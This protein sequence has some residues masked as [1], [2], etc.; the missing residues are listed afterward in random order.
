ML[1]H[2][3][4]VF[5]IAI[6]LGVLFHRYLVVLK[7]LTPCFIFCIL[8]LSFSAFQIKNLKFKGLNMW[9][10]IFQIV[11]SISAYYLFRRRSELLAQGFLIGIICPVAAS[12]SVVACILGAN[13][14]TITSYTLIGNLAVA[15]V[16]PLYFT[17]IGVHPEY[18]FWYS[19]LMILAKLAPIL[20]LPLIVALLLQRFAPKVTNVLVRY[21]WI[22]FYIWAVTL[23]IV[24]GQTIDYIFNSSR[25]Q[26]VTILVLAAASMITCFI[27]F[28]VGRWIGKK[29]GDTVSGG[30]GLAQKNAAM[31]VWMATIYLN[32]LASVF[33]ACYSVWQN[34][35]NSW[36]IYRHDKKE[37][38]KKKL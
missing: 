16:A 35:F 23:T 3:S 38:E 9:L 28:A 32:P 5:P 36:Q 21:N 26:T 2:R 12:V 15:I 29:Y 31:G 22:S 10:L 20:V 33:P 34:V 4:L 6:V 37:R 8:L 7:F 14:E 13:R 18:T 19:F 25:D 27:Q 24:I 30:Q 17:I 11:V 1:R